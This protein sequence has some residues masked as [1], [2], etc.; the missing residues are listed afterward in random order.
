M[1]EIARPELSEQYYRGT[2][3]P[4]VGFTRSVREQS[5]KVDF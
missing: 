1:K 3:E 2:V 5:S 4:T